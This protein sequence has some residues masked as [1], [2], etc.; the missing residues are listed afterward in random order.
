[1]RGQL[2]LDCVLYTNLYSFSMKNPAQVKT[3]SIT[4]ATAKGV[5][6]VVGLVEDGQAVILER[7]G[8][9]VAT[10][11]SIAKTLELEE[12]EDDLRSI[13]LI[14]ARMAGDDGRRYSLDEMMDLAGVTR[15]QLD[16]IP[17]DHPDLD[18][19]LHNE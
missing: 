18:I 16:D 10:V 2:G 15:A 17:S 19:D 7:H 14:M 13:A 3:L 6:G 11:M 4:E 5:S 12:Y 1:M 8:R 9:P